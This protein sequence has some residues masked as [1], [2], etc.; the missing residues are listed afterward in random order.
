[1]DA[2]PGFL[3]SLLAASARPGEGAGT[4]YIVLRASYAYLE[5]EMR[6]VFPGETGDV[7]V[8]V[9]R[10]HGERRSAAQPATPERRRADRRRPKEAIADVIIVQRD[11]DV[12]PS[13]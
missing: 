5:T 13:A 7:Q 12:Q 3:L 8:I 1:M 11:A 9:D 6:S 10:R 2:I 4:T